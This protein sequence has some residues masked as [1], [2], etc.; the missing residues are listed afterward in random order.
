[1]NLSP[2]KGKT[3]PIVPSV[4]PE[5]EYQEKSTVTI[6]PS[7]DS[8]PLSTPVRRTDKY[9]DKDGSVDGFLSIKH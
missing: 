5:V 6:R 2:R 3:T 7:H 1:M 9:V 4:K 8:L